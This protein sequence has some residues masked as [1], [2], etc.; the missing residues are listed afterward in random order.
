MN[1]LTRLRGRLVGRSVRTRMLLLLLAV[2]L[3][4]VAAISSYLI[5]TQRAAGMESV[6]IDLDL[7]ARE[8]VALLEHRIEE[9]RTAIAAVAANPI[10]R[11]AASSY[12]A[13]QTQ[14]DTARELY[15]DFDDITIV[16]PDGLAAASTDYAYNGAWTSKAWFNQATAGE[17]TVSPAHMAGAPLHLVLVFAS[18]VRRD[19]DGAVIAVVAGQ[20]SLESLARPLAAASRGD[21]SGLSVL[22]ARGFALVGVPGVLPLSPAP[23]GIVSDELGV[24]TVAGSMWRTAEIPQL[25]LVVAA[26]IDSEVVVARTNRQAAETLLAGAG[27]ALAVAVLALV[28]SN[29]LSRAV[30]DI[31][32]VIDRIGEG[33][34]DHRI[35]PLGLVEIDSLVGAFN[36]MAN[37]LQEARAEVV[38]S[39]EWF[40]SLVVRGSDVVWVLDRQLHIKYVSPT[41]GRVLGVDP[42]ALVGVSFLDL[43]P[44]VDRPRLSR[45]IADAHLDPPDVEHGMRGLA[46]EVVLESS[47]S[48]LMDVPA[49]EG[50]VINTRDV[51]D[52]KALEADVERALELDRLKTEFV[53]LASHELRTPLTGIYGFSELLLT[54][55]SLPPEEF[56]WV[57]TINSEA[58]RLREIID[59]LL[60]V[61]RIE[62]GGFAIALAPVSLSAAIEEALRTDLGTSSGSHEVAVDIPDG[63]EV[64]A[65]RRRLV[66]VAENV[67]GNAIKY[68]PLGGRIEISARA[69]GA[70]VWISVSDNGLG[71]PAHAMP[72]LFERFKRVDTPDRANIR[73]TGLGLYLVKRYVDS[74]GGRVEVQS[75]LG[76]GSTFTIILNGVTPEAVAA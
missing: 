59:G 33:H 35:E 16:T 46:S 38:R 30:T 4:P 75:E 74:F 66:E 32:L 39:E 9:S 26:H 62:S 6:A 5:L 2:G 42:D 25:G 31:S 53:G 14:L 19:T 22:D 23:A 58:S 57:R 60:N 11:N 47:V 45:A 28:L 50:F 52:R 40:R 27:I 21:G 70:D 65:D 41:A 3:V 54:S 76:V 63:C 64:W 68:S 34:L 61:S 12:D 49:I 71:I 73:G 29:R 51:T 7:R 13:W 15:P 72:T 67:V 69:H 18:P 36:S 44:S 20:V 1:L 8:G 48:D 17:T 37:R 24:H 43:V 10:I 56:E 55:G